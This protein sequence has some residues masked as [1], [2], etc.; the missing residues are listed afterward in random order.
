MIHI[1]LFLIMQ[2]HLFM[3]ALFRVTHILE[4]RGRCFQTNVLLYNYSKHAYQHSRSKHANNHITTGKE[5]WTR[6]NFDAS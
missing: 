6:L 4:S 5:A 2:Y 1:A 3:C